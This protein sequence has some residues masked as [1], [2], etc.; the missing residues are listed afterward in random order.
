MESSSSHPMVIIRQST[1]H[2]PDIMNCYQSLSTI[3]NQA[4]TNQWYPPPT[5]SV[6][7]HFDGANSHEQSSMGVGVIPRNSKDIYLARW[8]KYFSFPTTPDH[9]E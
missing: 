9:L 7:V 6:K 3:Q 4:Q 8:M 2:L 1:I 5:D